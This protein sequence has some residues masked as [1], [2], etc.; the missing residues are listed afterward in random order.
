[1]GY[2]IIDFIFSRSKYSIENAIELLLKEKIEEWNSLRDLNSDWTPNLISQDLSKK[3]LIGVN[4]RKCK[5]NNVN[6]SDSL[7][8]DSDFSGATLENANFVNASLKRVVFDNANLTG[9]K[10]MAAKLEKISLTDTITQDSDILNLIKDEV[11]IYKIIN[12]IYETPDIIDRLNHNDFEI[13]VQYILQ[14]KGFEAAVMSHLEAKDKGYDIIAYT[15]DPLGVKRYLVECKSSPIA[16]SI[17]VAP[18]ATLNTIRL[19]EN[20]DKAMIITN[21]Y[22]SNEAKELSNKFKDIELID[23]DTFIEWI[24]KLH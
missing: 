12:N 6:F 17:G 7:L 13:V 10:F 14:K 21:S 15:Q 9:A 23:R 11:S 19:T 2:K 4:L 18:I 22:F 5:L 8:D 20:A 16:R 3:Y 1:M 24:K